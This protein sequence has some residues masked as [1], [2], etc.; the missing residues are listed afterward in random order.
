MLFIKGIIIGIGKI[1]PGVSGSMLAI[2]LGVYQN[3]IDSI[4][5]FFV[6]PVEN[7][8]FLSKIGIG[9]LVSI[10]LFSKIIVKSLNFSYFTTVFFFIGLII[11]S[12]DDLRNNIEGK[13]NY[14]SVIIFVSILLL[15]LLNINNTV[16]ITNPFFNTLFFLFVGF[17]DAITM[18]IPGISGTATLMMLGAY[19]TIINSLSNLTSLNILIPFFSGVLIGI[20][21]T[22][23][24]VD[25]LFKRHKS[26]TY[27]AIIGFTLST[28]VLM[29]IKCLK[30]NFSISEFFVAVILFTTG[31]LVTKSLSKLKSWVYTIQIV[32]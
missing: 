4:N 19:D 22:A 28:I 11:G 23:K 15:G 1:I 32:L 3:M 30:T 10:V 24:L 8:K 18:V 25:Y 21:L 7:A 6:K 16:T 29:I 2:S 5:C 27:S 26:K 9:I 31:L 14:I 17:V 12:L 20:I 13:N